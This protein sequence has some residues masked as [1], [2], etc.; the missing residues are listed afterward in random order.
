MKTSLI[1]VVKDTYGAVSYG[2]ILSR[3]KHRLS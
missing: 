3:Q 1:S 2:A